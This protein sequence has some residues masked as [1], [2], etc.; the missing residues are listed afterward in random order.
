M[1]TSEVAVAIQERDIVFTNSSLK[2]SVLYATAAKK[3]NL[4]L[5]K[6]LRTRQKYHFGVI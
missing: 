6:I 1:L 2:S 5:G 4:M 3:V